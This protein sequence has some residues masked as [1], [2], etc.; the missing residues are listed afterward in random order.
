M[1]FG[2]FEIAGWTPS[3]I[4]D[5]HG[6]VAIVTGGNSGVGFFT[7][8]ELARHGA[9]TYLACR[10]RNR[11]EEAV[12][13]IK[14]VVPD[15]DLE[16]LNFDLTRI[17]SAHLAAEDFLKRETRLD[18]LVNNA[19]I[20][21][22]GYELSPDGIEVQ[23]CNGT[24]HFAFTI[25]LLPILIETSK[26]N[27]HVRIVNVASEAHRAAWRPDFSSLLGINQKSLG[28]FFRYS[29][30]KLSNILFT[31][32]L[33]K[34][35]NNSMVTCTSVH[36]GAVNTNLGNGYL[37]AF[38]ILKLIKW[39]ISWFLT[40]A[41]KGAYNQLYAST[42]P[43]AESSEFKGAYLVPNCKIGLKSELARDSDGKLGEQ[44][45]NLCEA[46]VRE[47]LKP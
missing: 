2:L 45:W 29:N 24:G 12:K 22:S 4:P 39:I 43:E 5:L 25:P 41:E 15:A 1:L 38:P 26:Y 13:K 42:S 9:K 17:H 3:D 10:D 31:N 21:S 18:I 19:G 11:A 47:N 16:I 37:K 20:L 44:F 7:S 28:R 30:S 27:P 46:L 23:A 35:L 33:Q 32:E 6:R 40:S 8:L 34:K 14:D 36:P